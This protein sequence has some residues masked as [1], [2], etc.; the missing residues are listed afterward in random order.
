VTGTEKRRPGRPKGAGAK[1]GHRVTGRVSARGL[2]ALDD[3]AAARGKK[4]TDVI[5]DLAEHLADQLGI[6]HQ[7]DQTS[8]NGDPT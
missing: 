7:P 1:G 6:A 2:K 8:Q 4:R 5:G 3:E